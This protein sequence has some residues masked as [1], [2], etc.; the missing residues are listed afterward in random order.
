MTDLIQAAI[1]SLIFAIMFTGVADK[2]F[3]NVS[4]GTVLYVSWSIPMMFAIFVYS[5][6]VKYE[7]REIPIY[8][9]KGNCDLCEDM[10]I[11]EENYQHESEEGGQGQYAPRVDF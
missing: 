8:I 5:N 1:Y 9:D 7:T 3:K 2:I 4:F 11:Q 10:R 6:P